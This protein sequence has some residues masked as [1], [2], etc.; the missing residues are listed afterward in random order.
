MDK[1]TTAK[2]MF[3]HL[4]VALLINGIV[5]SL[6]NEMFDIPSPL[7]FFVQVIFV[8]TTGGSIFAFL[9]NIVALFG[10]EE[11]TEKQNQKKK[12]NDRWIKLK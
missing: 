8:L 4:I 2:V 10:E 1:K 3:L 9:V 7:L 11:A 12:N 6:F 5:Y